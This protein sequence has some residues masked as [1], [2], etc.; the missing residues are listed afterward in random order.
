[1]ANLLNYDVTG[2]K[3]DVTVTDKQGDDS[4]HFV[5]T[6]TGNSDGTFTNLIACYQNWDGNWV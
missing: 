2:V 5:I 1:M 6:V 3:G 4:H